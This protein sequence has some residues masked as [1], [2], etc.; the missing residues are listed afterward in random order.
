MNGKQ[1]VITGATSGIGLAAAETLAREV[2]ASPSSAARRHGPRL[3]H[4]KSGPSQEAVQPS[5]PSLP[6]CLRRRPPQAGAGHLDRYPKF[7]IL[8]NN[9]GAMHTTRQVTGDGIELTWAVNHLAP[10]PAHDCSS[11]GS[12]PAIPRG[13]S[14]RRR[15]RITGPKFHS[16][17]SMPR[18]PIEGSAATRNPSSPISSSPASCPPPWR[19]CSA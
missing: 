6:T 7:D 12:R 8:I 4:H 16:T 19:P 13:S 9:A 2:P 14:P 3:A 1:I 18:S 15:R 17:T 10:V 11:T 5:I